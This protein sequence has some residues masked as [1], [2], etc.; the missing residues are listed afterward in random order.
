MRK[1]KY[2]FVTV[3][4]FICLDIFIVTVL[5]GFVAARGLIQKAL[6]NKGIKRITVYGGLEDGTFSRV[7]GVFSDV[8]S[9]LILADG[10]TVAFSF[11]VSREGFRDADCV[12]D[13]AEVA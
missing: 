7:D 11:H 9:Y 3:P 5:P 6:E 13:V 8:C 1:E 10:L 4:L 2:N 12:A